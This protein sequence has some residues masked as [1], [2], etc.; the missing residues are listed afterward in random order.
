MVDVHDRVFGGIQLLLC[1][2]AVT[3]GGLAFVGEIF[4][5][6]AISGLLSFTAVMVYIRTRDRF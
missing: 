5:A 1:L 4:V 2:F 3:C 6:C